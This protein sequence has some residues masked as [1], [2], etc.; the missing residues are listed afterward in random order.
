M[1]TYVSIRFIAK[2]LCQQQEDKILTSDGSRF[3]SLYREGS[4]STALSQYLHSGG[5]RGVSIRFIAKGLCQPF[6]S[7]M[8][9]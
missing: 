5:V 7:G 8:S 6:P 1:T 2:G 4:L 9:D 3:Y